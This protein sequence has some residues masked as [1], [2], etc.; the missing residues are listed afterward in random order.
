MISGTKWA[1]T[2]AGVVQDEFVEVLGRVSGEGASSMSIKHCKV[3][4]AGIQ[5][6]QR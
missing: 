5:R 6:A 3:S 2:E 1:L 4:R